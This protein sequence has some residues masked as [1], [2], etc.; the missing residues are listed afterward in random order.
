MY[1]VNDANL[2]SDLA[3]FR[4]YVTIFDVVSIRASK[5]SNLLFWAAQLK[6]LYDSAKDYYE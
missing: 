6:Y 2:S 5:K 3:R 1:I 4:C